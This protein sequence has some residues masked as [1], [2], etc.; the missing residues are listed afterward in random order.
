MT[1]ERLA[2]IYGQRPLCYTHVKA[3]IL[4]PIASSHHSMPIFSP[5]YETSHS[6]QMPF[7]FSREVT[8]DL[9]AGFGN[10]LWKELVG[11]DSKKMKVTIV[12]LSFTGIETGEAGQ[13]TIEGF[14]KPNSKRSR[15]DNENDI[16]PL[17]QDEQQEAQNSE[18]NDGTSFICPRCGKRVSLP[19]SY[20]GE[21]ADRERS[22]DTIRMEHEDFH[23]AQ[24]L[25]KT[26]DND[27]E[28][29]EVKKKRLAKPEGIAKFF[30]QK[31]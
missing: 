19:K 18:S 22:L 15:D 4:N 16:A 31:G 12:Q 5:G 17:P 23:F 13:K 6:K 10:R 29:R 20:P 2:P 7:P 28:R 30:T 25:A 3:L 9:I 11:A 1:Q 24:D 27:G 21:D 14:L 26:S 8:V